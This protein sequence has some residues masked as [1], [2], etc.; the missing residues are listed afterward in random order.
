[1]K[2]RIF[3]CEQ[4][5]D[6]A[7]Q[8]ITYNCGEGEHLTGGKV[9]STKKVTNWEDLTG[10]KAVSIKNDPVEDLP[11]IARPKFLMPQSPGNSPKL[12]KRSYKKRSCVGKG[13]DS[14]QRLISHM[15]SPSS[16]RALNVVEKFEPEEEDVHLM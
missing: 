13:V 15:M 9:V 7:Q 12:Q 6:S 4:L 8:E 3:E 14:R 16:S 2:Y 10:G 1:M 5:V 11:K